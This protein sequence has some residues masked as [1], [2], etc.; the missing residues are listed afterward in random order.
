MI[1]KH[2]NVFFTGLLAAII[3][4]NL[5]AAPKLSLIQTALPTVTVP[6]GENSNASVDAK[7]TGDGSLNLQ[8]KSSAPWLVPTVGPAHNCSDNSGPG[9]LPI[10]MSLQTSSLSAGTYTAIV[11]VNDPNAVDAPQN[12]QVS[13]QVGS[14]VP[15]KL[16]FWVIMGGSEGAQFIVNSQAMVKGAADKWLNVTQNGGSP[17]SPVLPYLATV[18]AGASAPGDYTSSLTVSGSPTATDNKT[19]AVTMHVVAQLISGPLASIGGALNNATYGLGEPLAQGDIVALF[20]SQFLSGD[21]VGASNLPLDTTLSGVQVLVNNQPAPLYYVSAGQINF[22]MPFNATIG[23][24]TVQVVSN[25][26]KGNLISVQIAKAAPRIL[27]LGGTFGDYGIVLN[28][29]ALSIPASLGGV[30]A[31]VGDT[32]VL[33]AIGLGPASTAVD[34]GAASPSSPLAVVTDNA[35]VCFTAN[36]PFIN[37]PS[38]VTPD[39]A[40]LAPGFVGLYQINAVVPAGTASADFVPLRLSTS[41]G[42]SNVVNIAVQ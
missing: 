17:F 10:Q 23:S 42:D 20:G 24:G 5:M 4:A 19:I 18:S 22:Q 1:I 33:Y 15:S 13:A 32:I 28:G 8:V 12:V 27:R 21:P 26:T 41:D 29:T 16:E 38:C 6:L 40:G 7:N 35:K 36:S 2:K 14:G 3:A 9:C 11:S 31:H 30:P 25:G 37:Q 34:S 39:F